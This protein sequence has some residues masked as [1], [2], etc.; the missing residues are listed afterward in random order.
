M[1]R[2]IWPAVLSM[3][4]T[5]W[6]AVLSMLRTI[7]PAVVSVL[8]TI[9]FPQMFPQ[10]SRKTLAATVSCHPRAQRILLL[11]NSRNQRK[12]CWICNANFRMHKSG[13]NV[14]PRAR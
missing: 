11:V 4:R 1:L 6:P 12:R 9:C 2:T 5:I 10:I 7:W 14:L 13:S 3:L 8:Q